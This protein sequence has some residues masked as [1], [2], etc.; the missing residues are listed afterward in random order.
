M[1]LVPMPATAPDNSDE[2]RAQLRAHLQA[3]D[4][5]QAATSQKIGVSSTTLSRWLSAQYEGDNSIIEDKV[6]AYLALQGE[7]VAK[8]VR[9]V[10][11]VETTASKKLY[12][13]LTHA[14]VCSDIVV[15][16]G[17]PGVSKTLTCQEYQ[18]RNPNVWHVELSPATRSAKNTLR[19]IC[20]VLHISASN[21]I[22]AMQENVVKK[23][24]NSQGLL[25]LDE[26]QN[27]SV[28]AIEQTR[29][30]WDKAKI[31]FAYVAN[32]QFL[33]G[34]DSGKH[35]EVLDRFR[36]RI[37]KQIKVGKPTKADANKIMDAWGIDGDCRAQLLQ[38]ANGSGA[39]REMCTVLKNAARIAQSMG[40]ELCCDHI[41]AATIDKNGVI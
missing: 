16:F 17:H 1:Q 15:M 8:R 38:I 2:I 25:V 21:D 31:G 33:N 14:Q 41:A 10:G 18:S 39:L 11:Y 37:V 7:R 19:A 29:H 22:F 4:Q 28:E 20:A 23:L 36:S 13:L 30:I 40:A 34:I 3:T 27:L 6:K 24:S 32:Q 5:S 9:N 26:A 12:S 35:C